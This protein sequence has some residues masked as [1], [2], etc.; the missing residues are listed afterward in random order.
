MHPFKKCRKEKEKGDK[1]AG[2][3]GVQVVYFQRMWKVT[4]V[5]RWQEQCI[6]GLDEEGNTLIIEG[7][8]KGI[9]GLWTGNP[10]KGITFEM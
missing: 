7:E 5:Q 3:L 2:R 10:G 8:G 1:P 4:T 6:R 9:G